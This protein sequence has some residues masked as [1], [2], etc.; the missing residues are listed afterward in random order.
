VVKLL[1]G[2]LDPWSGEVLLNGNPVS[3]AGMA[4]CAA[5]VE[6]EIV[7]FGDTIA[8]NLRLGNA[9]ADVAEALRVTRLEDVL[10]ARPDGMLLDNGRNFSGGQRQRLDIARALARKAGLILLDEAVN[11]LDAEAAALIGSEL[12]RRGCAVF[13]VS[14]RRDI[15]RMADEILVLDGGRIVER[16]SFSELLRTG[17]VFQKLLAL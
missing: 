4:F 13:Q 5:V 12:Q 1:S 6:Q 7:F 3:P 14:H 16:G 17:P 11:G 10:A 8:A 15:M 2:L 9:N